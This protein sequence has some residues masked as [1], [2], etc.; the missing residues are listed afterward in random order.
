MA[1][2]HEVDETLDDAIARWTAGI[3]ECRAEGGHQWKR[4]S[5]AHRPGVLT[6]HQRCNRCRATERE[7]DYNEHGYPISKLKRDYRKDFLLRG[8]GRLDADDKAR[9]MITVLNTIKWI[10]VQDD[11]A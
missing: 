7:R 1:E 3:L 8:L 4:L 10:E 9:L 6:V 5:V 2:S 11:V